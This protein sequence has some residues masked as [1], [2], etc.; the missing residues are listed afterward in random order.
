MKI[1]E[2]NIFYN[3]FEWRGSIKLR[4]MISAYYV[5]TNIKQL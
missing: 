5:K 4:K 1:C 2:K 3:N